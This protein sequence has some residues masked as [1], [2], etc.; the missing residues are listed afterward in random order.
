[1]RRLLRKAGKIMGQLHMCRLSTSIKF[2]QYFSEINYKLLPNNIIN[3]IED[4]VN[5]Q[6]LLTKAITKGSTE[7]RTKLGRVTRIHYEPGDGES[8]SYYYVYVD[9]VRLSMEMI[10]YN[11]SHIND[12]YIMVYIEDKLIWAMRIQDD[13]SK[14]FNDSFGYHNKLNDVQK[15]ALL[16]L[17][18]TEKLNVIDA[19][20]LDDATTKQIKKAW[21]DSNRSTNKVLRTLDILGIVGIILGILVSQ[22]SFLDEIGGMLFFGS[23]FLLLVLLGIRIFMLHSNKLIRK[24]LYSCIIGNV[25]NKMMGATDDLADTYFI[26]INNQVLDVSKREYDLINIGDYCIEVIMNDSV[27]L[28]IAN[29]KNIY[30][31]R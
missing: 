11:M 27:R 12:L 22:I 29:G 21:N 1:M 30:D 4:S 19:V 18:Q 20:R 15:R 24:K 13:V 5:R 9:D 31:V 14:E 26:V 8:P 16:R 6:G 3:V 17:H 28:S 7:Y 2:D 25:D 10:D 23:I